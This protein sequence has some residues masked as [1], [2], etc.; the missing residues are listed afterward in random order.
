MSQGYGPALDVDLFRVEPQDPLVGQAC[1]RKGL[2]DLIGINILFLQAG[3]F[4]SNGY[5]GGGA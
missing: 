1:G 4:K 3:P 2:V 5:G